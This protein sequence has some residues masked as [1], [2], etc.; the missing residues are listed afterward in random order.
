MRSYFNSKFFYI[1]TF[2]TL[3]AV[4]IPTVLCFMGHTSLFRNAVNYVFTP[5]RRLAVEV[6]DAVDGYARYVYNFDRLAEENE[7]LKEEN[8]KLRDELSDS[9]E[10]REQYE[11][12]SEYL[13]LKMEH[14]DYEFVPALVLGA[15]SGNYSDIYM[16]DA[17]S[18]D[19]VEK[20]MTVLSDGAVL[21]YVSEVGVNWARVTSILASTAAVGV[22]TERSG[23]SGVLEGDYSLGSDGLCRINYLPEN[24]DLK[25]GDKILTGGFGSVYPRG[26]PVGYVEK[27]ELNEFSRTSV[28]Y[29]RP[30]ATDLSDTDRISKVMVITS[31]ETYSE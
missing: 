13:E 28:A 21:G 27:V 22:Y 19:G 23:E 9:D 8:E 29:V 24:A 4:I 1:I 12:L 2:L 11:W 7:R 20:N 3:A 15:E 31:Y 30:E 26:L 5:L 14:T 10:L 6:T 25:V 16:I 18:S 17:G